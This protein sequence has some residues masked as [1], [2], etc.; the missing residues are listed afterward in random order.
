MSILPFFPPSA[1]CPW[2][3]LNNI[4]VKPSVDRLTRR[5]YAEVERSTKSV[6]WKR[7][8][9]TIRF[10]LWLQGQHPRRQERRREKLDPRNKDPAVPGPPS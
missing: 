9:E 1:T 6:A 5:L 2:Q 7:N 8:Q 4:T 10:R 3:K